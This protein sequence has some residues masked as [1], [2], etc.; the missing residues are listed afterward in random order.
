MPN[1]LLSSLSILQQGKL[2]IKREEIMMAT[3]TEVMMFHASARKRQ[4]LQGVP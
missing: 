3:E 1:S 4:Q 2:L